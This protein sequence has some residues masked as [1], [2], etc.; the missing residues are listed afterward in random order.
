V[1]ATITALAASANYVATH[2]SCGLPRSPATSFYNASYGRR[3]K[4]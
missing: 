2:G 4:N 1:A 3:Q